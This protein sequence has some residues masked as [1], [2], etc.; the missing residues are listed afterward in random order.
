MKFGRPGTANTLPPLPVATIVLPPIRAPGSRAAR[1]AANGVALD[2][3]ESPKQPSTT[4]T[5]TTASRRIPDIDL[6]S[7]RFQTGPRAPANRG[8]ILA[9][10]G[11]PRPNGAAKES[12]LPSGGLPRP[13]GF[14]DRL[15][16]SSACVRARLRRL[17]C[18]H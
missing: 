4:A 2:V 9:H 16:S 17:A 7:G 6:L 11:N 8:A 10:R 15:R 1:S 14:E 3:A 12:N 18:A 5:S 13:A